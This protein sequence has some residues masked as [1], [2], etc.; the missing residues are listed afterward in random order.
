MEKNRRLRAEPPNPIIFRDRA[1][2]TKSNQRG[3][4]KKKT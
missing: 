4:E 3:T 1:K 2:Q